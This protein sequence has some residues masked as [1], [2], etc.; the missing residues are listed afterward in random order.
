VSQRFALKNDR[1]LT[2]VP[3]QSDPAD[4]FAGLGRHS[5]RAELRSAGGPEPFYDKMPIDTDV[6]QQDWS[7]REKQTVGFVRFGI[8]TEL[9][10]IP[11]RGNAGVQ[12]V[13]VN[14]EADGKDE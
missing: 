11:V 5:R 1:A 14:Q 8:D 3:F 13:H 2:T 9:G 10:T 4:H 6:A 7:V 12:Y